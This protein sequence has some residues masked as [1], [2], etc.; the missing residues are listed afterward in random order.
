MLTIQGT[1]NWFTHMPN[2]SPHICFSRGI[3]TLPPPDSFSQWPRSS[4]V[5]SPLRL[6][7]MLSPGLK[8]IPGGVSAPIS[9]KPPSVSS[10]LCMILSASGASCAPNSPKG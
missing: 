6:T 4:S 8:S 3:D 9:V 7:A 5:S 10:L 1:P 2:W